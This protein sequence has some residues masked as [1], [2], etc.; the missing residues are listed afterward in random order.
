MAGSGVGGLICRSN[1]IGAVGGRSMST[2]TGEAPANGR[3]R[4]L[5]A[6]QRDEGG[7]SAVAPKVWVFFANH[8]E[9]C[10]HLLLDEY[11]TFSQ[12]VMGGRG[13][14]RLTQGGG[15]GLLLELRWIV[16]GA[17]ALVSSDVFV[18]PDGLADTFI[19]GPSMLKRVGGEAIP[20]QGLY[21]E[22]RRAL[23]FSSTG[24]QCLPVV[25]D[26]WL[27][28]PSAVRFDV[29]LVFYKDTDSQVWRDLEDLQR[30]HSFLQLHHHK[31][32]KWP[33]FV[34]WMD[35]EGGVSVI[36]A[37]YD[38]VWVVDDDVR[39]PTDSIN[40]MFDILRANDGIQFACPSF[41]AESDGVWRYFDAHDS[42]YKLRYTD[43][44]ECTAPV[45]KTSMLL[46]STFERC[47]RATRTG[48]FLDFCFHAVS[49]ARDDAIAIVDAVQCNHPPRGPDMP[50]E[51]RELVPW[52]DHK[53]DAVHF[54][55]AGLLKDWWWYRKPRVIR[56]VLAPAFASVSRLPLGGRP[57]A[58]ASAVDDDI[59]DL[60]EID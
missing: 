37:R 29:V 4:G 9:W 44:V 15:S 19:A 23:V 45:I 58:T 25:R 3:S 16:V 5:V 50:S 56:G 31:E 46:D 57:L 51:M 27:R 47:L 26:T 8:R 11:G 18:S 32:M 53:Q 10:D 39:L 42:R 21:P 24:S 35:I 41:D 28:S 59:D 7:R 12:A 2:S 30:S 48:C 22:K 14:W 34:R 20:L 36:A 6:P 60:E 40:D 33:N 43:F 52:S 55:R 17:G 54:E 13:T 1:Y 49:G 38:Y